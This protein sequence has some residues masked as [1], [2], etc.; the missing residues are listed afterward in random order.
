MPTKKILKTFCATL[1]VATLSFTQTT[2]AAIITGL[3]LGDTGP[4]AI[5][6]SADPS[7]QSVADSY[8]FTVGGSALNTTTDQTQWQAFT[9]TGG[10][11]NVS[12]EYL[13]SSASYNNQLGV[14][15]AP[16]SNPTDITYMHA[17]TN[18]L[19]PIGT[20]VTLTVDEDS[21]FGFYVNVNSGSQQFYTT[22]DLN[23]DNKGSLVTDHFLIFDT[24]QGLLVGLEDIAYNKNTGKLGDQDY[25]DVI[26]NVKVSGVPEPASAALLIL[27]G[28][29]LLGRPSRKP[30]ITVA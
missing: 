16:I 1:I 6:S 26:F 17:F 25:N 5:Y 8:G 4:D 13:G 27:G 29:L 21:I 10:A 19:D 7:L 22:N 2:R 9:I 12:F 20:T 14:F 23:E 28:A 15:Y 24:D 18:N 3:T 11:A 30:R